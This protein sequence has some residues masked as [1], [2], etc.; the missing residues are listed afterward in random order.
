MNSTS[1][2]VVTFQ[3][4]Y[5]LSAK[6][7]PNLLPSFENATSTMPWVFSL[8]VCSNARS[9]TVSTSMTSEGSSTIGAGVGVNVGVC[10]GS[11]VGEAVG[12]A[13]GVG[14]GVAVGS[15]AVEVAEFPV[16]LVSSR[17]KIISNRN[18]LFF[19]ACFSCLRSIT[20]FYRA[21]FIVLF[22]MG[23]PRDIFHHCWCYAMQAKC[24][25]EIE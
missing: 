20:N 14:G 5:S 12:V 4:L 2:K 7:T 18:N 1:C 13:L 15:V 3:T 24:H 16:Q 6:T 21:E 9:V 10:V 22:F 19:M 17:A 23:F 8:M 11:L 25:Q